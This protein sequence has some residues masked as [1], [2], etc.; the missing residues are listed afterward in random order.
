[1]D[2]QIKSLIKMMKKSYIGNTTGKVEFFKKHDILAKLL[3]SL[4]IGLLLF[5]VT[6]K[7]IDIDLKLKIC[8]IILVTSFIYFNAGEITYFLVDFNIYKNL[9]FMPVSIRKIVK[10][11]LMVYMTDQFPNSLIT[12]FAMIIPYILNIE[13]ISFETIIKFVITFFI[14]AYLIMGLIYMIF[15]ILF[16]VLIGIFNIKMVKTIFKSL[17]IMVTAIAYIIYSFFIKKGYGIIPY[18]INLSTA[19]V[20]I[21][22]STIILIA[23]YR[24]HASFY[25]KN[26]YELAN[27][28]ENAEK[29]ES[30]FSS[31]KISNVNALAKLDNKLLSRKLK[32][33]IISTITSFI[34]IM[35]FL[36]YPVL[37]DIKI[38]NIESSTK[39]S[40]IF[41]YLVFNFMFINT[42][43]I[44]L[45]MPISRFA[46]EF[47]HLKMMLTNL[48]DLIY[49]NIRR[50]ILLNLIPSI[51]SVVVIVIKF[52]INL[53]EIILILI[54]IILINIFNIVYTLLNIIAYK[55]N[56][57]ITEYKQLAQVN[58]YKAF[59]TFIGITILNGIFSGLVYAFGNIIFAIQLG[60]FAIF[61]MRKVYLLSKIN[62]KLELIY[63][64]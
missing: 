5:T 48:N 10:S 31:K 32:S 60:V 45:T 46:M 36:I 18:K 40:L 55:P 21:I 12:I 57:N 63:R 9:I 20:F 22:L 6:D 49:L 3:V 27:L 56:V 11:N 52:D 4:F 7:N 25:A 41:T 2:R 28:K 44:F 17:N 64:S 38:D 24:L 47:N 61:T 58:S 54:M 26:L 23:T 30:E 1:M 8:M 59:L 16:I 14:Y 29:R 37:K 43:N 42:Y 51:F 13:V 19:L 62:E 33:I 34:F 53:I 35:G 39:L 15:I 50:A